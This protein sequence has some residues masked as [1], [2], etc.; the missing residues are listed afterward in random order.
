MLTT[1]CPSR[2]VLAQYAGGRLDD[3]SAV[4]LDAHLSQCETCLSALESETPADSLVAG[5]RRIPESDRDSSAYRRIESRLKSGTLAVPTIPGYE[6]LE[7]LGQGGMGTVYKAMHTRLG[8]TVAVKVIRGS[9]DPAAVA[10]FER[11]MKAVGRLDHPNVV[12]ATDAG[13]SGGVPYLVMEYVPGTDLS[14]LVKRNGPLLPEI[15]KR[16]VAQLASALTAA[17]A[18]GIVHRDVKPSNAILADDGTVKLLDLGLALLPNVEPEPI[19]DRPMRGS[20][21]GLTQ[22]G[23]AVG[24]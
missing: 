12:R 19:S 2:E 4:A 21:R 5:L 13:E 9:R 22:T 10:R 14:K 20:E 15:A 24:T 11:E 8:K 7:P 16:Y 23:R 3:D 6:I 1:N 17:H 18:A